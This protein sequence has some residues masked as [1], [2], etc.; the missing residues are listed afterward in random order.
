MNDWKGKYLFLYG[1]HNNKTKKKEFRS[2]GY[3]AD[4]VI[5]P[6]V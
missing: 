2:I 4:L 1:V 6:I 3:A 5:T